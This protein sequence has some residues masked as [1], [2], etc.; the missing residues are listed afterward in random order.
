MNDDEFDKM[1]HERHD[2]FVAEVTAHAPPLRRHTPKASRHGT[3]RDFAVL[4]AVRSEVVARVVAA[5][6]AVVIVFGLSLRSDDKYYVASPSA[7][8]P[9]SSETMPPWTVLPTIPMS[10]PLLPPPTSRPMVASASGGGIG[11]LPRGAVTIDSVEIEFAPNSAALTSD[12]YAVLSRFMFTVANDGRIHF[13]LVGR[14]ASVGPADSAVD[15]SLARANSVRAAMLDYGTS[16]DRITV[17]A[18][19]YSRPLVSDRDSHGALI[20]AAAQ[21]NRSVEIQVSG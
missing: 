17:E 11:T 14:T 5:T 10:G 3:W 4:F 15:L 20:P 1:L 19:G 12:A 6:I 9:P 18:V 2:S 8:D 16:A 7:D 13:T 21:R